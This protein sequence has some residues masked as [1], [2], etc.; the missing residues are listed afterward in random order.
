MQ[1]HKCSINHARRSKTGAFP[2]SFGDVVNDP[3]AIHLM[4]ELRYQFLK[5]STLVKNSVKELLSLV[6][7][8]GMSNVVSQPY[9]LRKIFIQAETTGDRARRGCNESDMVHSGADMV[10]LGK[11]ENLRF[12]PQTSKGLRVDNSVNVTL[13]FCA[14]F[15]RAWRLAPATSNYGC[16][17]AWEQLS[18]GSSELRH[19]LSLKR[20]ITKSAISPGDFSDAKKS[21]ICFPLLFVASNL[22]SS[23][24]RAFSVAEENAVS[25]AVV[26]SR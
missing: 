25:K 3:Q 1:P 24:N 21:L 12:M 17:L 11:I 22:G 19:I 23:L 13:E 20:S 9:C 10:V 4:R 5:D 18:F 15:I 7:E 8:R 6:A 14:E 26:M 16:V 2:I